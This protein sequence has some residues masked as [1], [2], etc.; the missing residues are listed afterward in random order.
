MSLDHT[1]PVPNEFF[2]WIPYLTHAELRVLLLVIR[3]T[4]GW[5][6]PATGNRKIKDRLTYDFIIKKTGVYR[7]ILSETIQR[8]VD[9][10]LLLVTDRQ[11][12]ILPTAHDRKGKWFLYFQFQPVRISEVTYSELRTEPIRDSEHNKRN[13]LKRN[14]KQKKTNRE[15]IERLKNLKQPLIEKLIM[16]DV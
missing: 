7:T 6:D 4:Y 11:S 13:T 12:I 10:K 2:D 9:K 8:L 3:Q 1:T 14:T 15:N 16:R 5:I